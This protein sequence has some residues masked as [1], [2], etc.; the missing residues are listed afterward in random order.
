MRENELIEEGFERVDIPVEESGDKTDYYYYKYDLNEHCA[1]ISSENNLVFGSNWIVRCYEMGLII[2]DV[3]DLQ[4]LIS[5]F[6]KSAK[7]EKCL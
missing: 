4:L 5:L 2:K 1:L 7:I 3:E 6:A